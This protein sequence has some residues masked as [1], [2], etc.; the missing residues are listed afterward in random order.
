MR[1][2]IRGVLFRLEDDHLS[3]TRRGAVNDPIGLAQSKH[4]LRLKRWLLLYRRKR[5]WRIIAAAMPLLIG[6]LMVILS[7]WAS[8]QRHGVPD[9]WLDRHF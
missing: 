2:N 9:G 1:I 7:V 3:V 5:Q 6:L 4:T 8:I